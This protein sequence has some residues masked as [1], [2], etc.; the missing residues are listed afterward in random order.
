LQTNSNTGF[1]LDS[2]QVI[3]ERMTPYFPFLSSP[4]VRRDVQASILFVLRLYLIHSYL[5]QIEQALQDLNIA[6]C[7]LTSLLIIAYTTPHLAPSKHKRRDG[8]SIPMQISLVK[9]YITR[10]LSGISMSSHMV[11]RHITAQDYVALLPTLWM[12]LN[13]NMGHSDVDED[14]DTLGALLDHG[15][16]VSSAAAVK[17][18]TVDFLV[19]LILVGFLSTLCTPFANDF[20]FD[21]L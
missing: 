16:Q 14:D 15:L 20:D 10:L 21:T 7:E 8:N 2:L 3:L 1:L 17:R 19:R 9:D 4:L 5:D 11:G 12:L 18:P 13:S 6:F